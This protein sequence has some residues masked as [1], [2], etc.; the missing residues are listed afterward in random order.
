[1]P[2]PVIVIDPGPLASRRKLF[3][4]LL[5]A[6]AVFVLAVNV[7][8]SDVR[9]ALVVLIPSALGAVVMYFTENTPDAPSSK[10]LVTV[11]AALVTLLVFLVQNGTGEWRSALLVFAA[12]VLGAAGTWL[13][14]N[15]GQAFVDSTNPPAIPR[16]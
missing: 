14:P 3:A 8:G 9:S 2:A 15:A 5:G 13:T 10:F 16:A 7:P 6:A 1:M 4:A 12:A 11:V